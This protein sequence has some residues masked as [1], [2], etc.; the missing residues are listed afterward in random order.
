MSHWG[1][2]GN[3]L[4]A[5][6]LHARG[7]DNSI[8]FK[9]RRP[10]SARAHVRSKG[11]WATSSFK[12]PENV[13]CANRMQ[14]LAAV[15]SIQPLPFDPFS[16]S[17]GNTQMEF[18]S[19]RDSCS[20][21]ARHAPKDYSHIHFEGEE[22][23]TMVR[24]ELKSR[25]ADSIA[26]IRSRFRRADKNGCGNLDFSEFREL[27][28]DQLFITLSRENQRDLFNA[29]DTDGCGEIQY[30]EFLLQV[31][32]EMNNR[33]KRI[34]RWVF[35]KVDKDKSGVVDMNDV[36]DSY[37]ADAH[38]DVQAKRLKP[39]QQM[40]KFIRDFDVGGIP[41][42]KVT[43]KEFEDYYAALSAGIDTDQQFEQIMK[44]SWNM[45][46]KPPDK[47]T[48]E[49]ISKPRVA[50]S[51]FTAAA[52]DA[53]FVSTLKTQGSAAA[54]KMRSAQ[55]AA[56]QFKEQSSYKE[57]G[58]HHA[59][60]STNAKPDLDDLLSMVRNVLRSRGANNLAGV[61]SK[62][63]R[64]DKSNTHTLDFSEFRQL[65]TDELD[66]ELSDEDEHKL[67]QAYDRNGSGVIEYKEFLA[68]LCGEMS[69]YRNGILD[70]IFDS[71]DKDKSGVIDVKDF[72]DGKVRR[73]RAMK[74]FMK[75][76]DIEDVPNLKVSRQEF[77]DH[78]A[79]VSAGVDSDS[80][81]AQIMKSAWLKK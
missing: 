68:Q 30:E 60:A 26:G 31:R 62:F 51:H 14:K 52:Q 66:I 36:L 64:A 47:I 28:T 78:Y 72:V 17:L 10:S 42:G 8:P 1:G 7:S 55:G 39:I 44:S 46:G 18:L 15:P 75:L 73:L 33:R 50:R 77:K 54:L 38:P 59:E 6:A 58:R 40:K 80:Q 21:T 16:I 48:S 81:F 23:L 74:N 34:L 49:I 43:L 56:P 12:P 63:R 4:G 53:M 71:I 35:D 45:T 70:Q 5:G 41:D 32:G 20:E 29:Y 19:A 69:S 11:Q 37:N 9:S 22:L 67:F 76:F 24:N 25:G 3:L 2:V 65:L 27:M 57:T 79:A 61:R 13:S